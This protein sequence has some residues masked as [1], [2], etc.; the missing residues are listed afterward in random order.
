[1]VHKEWWLPKASVLTAKRL[2]LDSEA[3]YIGINEMQD[4]TTGFVISQTIAASEIVLEGG[5]IRERR[6]KTV[7][8]LHYEE[9]K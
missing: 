7:R 2:D 1:M 5:E 8:L 6:V 3:Y 4:S 9:K